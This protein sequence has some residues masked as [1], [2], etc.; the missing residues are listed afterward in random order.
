MKMRKICEVE[1]CN[2]MTRWEYDEH[3]YYK[4]HLPKTFD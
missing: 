3:V 1:G 4:K 2:E